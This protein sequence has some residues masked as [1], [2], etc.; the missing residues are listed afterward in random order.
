MALHNNELIADVTD[1][2]KGIPLAQREVIGTVLNTQ[3]QLGTGGHGI[4][5]FSVR[6]FLKCVKGR[7]YIGD[8]TENERGTV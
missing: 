1:T 3:L 5:L 2:G 6:R 8:N 4:G 7:M